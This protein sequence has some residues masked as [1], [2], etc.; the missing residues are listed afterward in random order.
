[1]ESESCHV[2]PVPLL[3]TFWW[4]WWTITN[5]IFSERE[6]SLTKNMASLLSERIFRC[7]LDTSRGGRGWRRWKLVT[8]FLLFF[9]ERSRLRIVLHSPLSSGG[10]GG[11]RDDLWEAHCSGQKCNA[12]YHVHHS[13]NPYFFM[14]DQNV[15]RNSPYR[16]MGKA[17]TVADHTTNFSKGTTG[18]T[19][20]EVTPSPREIRDMCFKNSF[21]FEFGLRWISMD[22]PMKKIHLARDRW[23]RR[24]LRWRRW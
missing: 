13:S 8:L 18:V 15:T 11:C 16:S 2:P 1:M 17:D 5:I 6:W 21:I 19:W 7:G 12:E 4:W 9:F 14:L 10:S 20:V 23:R 22:L 24:V 3:Q